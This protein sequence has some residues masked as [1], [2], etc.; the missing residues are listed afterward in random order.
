MVDAIRKKNMFVVSAKV[1]VKAVTNAIH[2][3]QIGEGED[4]KY[5]IVASVMNAVEGVIVVLV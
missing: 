4:W 2:L 1:A 5:T 3:A